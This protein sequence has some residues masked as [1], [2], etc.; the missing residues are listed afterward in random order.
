MDIISIALWAGYGLGI[1]TILGALGIRLVKGR[2]NAFAPIAT[3]LLLGG[4]YLGGGSVFGLSSATGAVISQPASTN[5]AGGAIN[6]GD[7]T[8]AT[9][10]ANVWNS[11]SSTV[12]RATADVFAYDENGVAFANASSSATGGASLSLPCGKTFRL[13]ALTLQN[14]H[15]GSDPNEVTVTVGKTQSV[16]NVNVQQLGS[17]AVRV[18]DKSTDTWQT[19]F[20]DGLTNAG[21]ANQSTE[22]SANNT[23]VYPAAAGAVTAIGSGGNIPYLIQMRTETADTQIGRASCRERVYVLV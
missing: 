6:C 10:I 20:L 5:L 1:I 4:V 17:P 23:F 22:G 15:T 9:V 2:I 21:A 14:A 3:A 13:S 18:K 8:S 11:S 7:V 16:V 19:L 12:T